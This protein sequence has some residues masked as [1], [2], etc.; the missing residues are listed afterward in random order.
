MNDYTIHKIGFAHNAPRLYKQGRALDHAGFT[1]G[2]RFT[3]KVDREQGFV[4]LKIDPSGARL[5]SAKGEG[6]NRIPV[7]DLNS[8]EILS[9]FDGM[10]Q[11]RVI[12]K[13]GAIF[14]LGLATEVRRT[15]RLKRLQ[16][17]LEAG[18]P[19]RIGSTSHG[20]GILSNAIHRG[21]TEEGLATELV[22]AN[23]IDGGYLD[24]AQAH[25]DAWSDTTLRIEAPLQELAFDDWMTGKLPYAHVIEAG[26]PCTASSNAGRAKKHLAKPEDDPNVGH[27]IVGY[28]ALIARCNPAVVVLENVENYMQT[29][30][31]GIFRSQMRDLGYEVHERVLEGA[32]FGALE[33]RKRL[34]AVAVT[35]GMTFDFDALAVP[36]HVVRTVSEI[37]EDVVLD[38]PCWSPMQYLKDKEVTD[39][40]AGK[41]FRMQPVPYDATS[42][43]TVTRGYMKRRSTDPFVQHPE[44]LDLLRLFTPIEH[45]RVKGVPPELIAGMSATQA[46]QVLGQGICF[47][48]FRHVG[49]LIGVSLKAYAALVKGGAALAPILR[50]ACATPAANETP[51][52]FA[53]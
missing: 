6:E 48:P 16:T 9:I 41:G 11:V 30:S 39:K 28:L 22:F 27:L 7:I 51:N 46:H 29:A 14:V 52:L 53:A 34:A 8:A 35:R 10:D 26:I 25:N 42:V 38:D 47:A 33:N 3:A 37:L 44:N 1:P 19:I 32:A 45:A 40:A 2:T 5:V 18:N 21:L 17:D 4:L 12:V 31:M 23:D 20:A 13:P 36:P 50:E 15:Q 24:Q 43:P 49:R